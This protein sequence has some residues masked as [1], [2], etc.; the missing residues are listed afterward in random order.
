LQEKSVGIS[1]LF[2][3]YL[4]MPDTRSVSEKDLAAL[5]RRSR[6]RSGDTRAEAARKMNV[7]QTSIFQAEEKPDQGLFK[8]RVRLIEAYSPY[9]VVGPVYHL[10]KK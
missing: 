10:K 8:L 6:M 4:Q 5:A 9:R 1:P 7:S 2:L 3:Q